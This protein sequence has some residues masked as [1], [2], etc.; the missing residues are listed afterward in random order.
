MHALV[1]ALPQIAATADADGYQDHFNHAW[2]SYTG[3]SEQ[4][5][6]GGKSALHPEDFPL[7]V[8]K[9]SRALR[10]GR[11]DEAE[12]RL[13]RADGVYR[14]HRIQALP[15]RDEKGIVFKWFITI[16][17]V[18]RQKL[19]GKRG[20]GRKSTR[21]SKPYSADAAR[22][23]HRHYVHRG[24]FG[25]PEQPEKWMQRTGLAKKMK[26]NALP[27][28]FRA[29]NFTDPRFRMLADFLPQII[30]TADPGGYQDFFNRQWFDLTGFTERE[31]Y[32]GKTALHPDDF[33]EY[34]ERWSRALR[35]GKA[36]EAEYRFF[37]ASDKTYRWHLVRG[38]PI[39]DDKGRIVKWF[40][41]FT[42]IHDMKTAQKAL[43]ESEQKYRDLVEASNSIILKINKDHNITFINDFGLKFFGYRA[44][45]LIGKN[46]IGTIVPRYD[47]TGRNLAR[48]VRDVVEQPE[49]YKTNVHKNMRKNGELV[50]VSWTN[51]PTYDR[52]GNLVSILAI[53]NDISPLKQ[54]EQALRESELRFKTITSH[55]PDHL[56]VQDRKLRYIF[57]LNPQLGFTEK[58]ML[59]KT[60]LELLRNEDGKRLMT[61]K[62]RAIESGKVHSFEIPITSPKGETEFF[63]GSYVP[64]FDAKGT[65]DGIIGYVRNVT[66]RKRVEDAL[67]LSEQKFSMAFANNPAA[68]V[69]TR[70]SDGKFLDV[71]DTWMEWL[72]YSRK[73]AFATTASKI[74]F[75]PHPKDRKRFVRELQRKGFIR[76]WEQE[77]RKKSGELFT[78]QISAQILNVRGEKV[79]LSTMI[80]IT[81]RKKAEEKIRLL[82]EGL[83]QRVRERTA[84]LEKL[85]A[86]DR[87]NLLRLQDI[88]DNV[89]YGIIALDEEGRVIHVNDQ[90]CQLFHFVGPQAILGKSAT[91]LREKLRKK[92]LSSEDLQ[93]LHA[94][95]KDRVLVF[96]SEIRLK[97]GRIFSRDYIPIFE[98]DV[99]HGHIAVYRDISREKRVDAAK[100]DFMS[101]ASHQLRTPLTAVRWALGRLRKEMDPSSESARLMS[102]AQ[103]AVRGMA[104]TINTMLSISRFEAGTIPL[105]TTEIP[106]VTFLQELS[107]TLQEELAARHQRLMVNCPSSSYIVTDRRLLTEVLLNLIINAINYSPE[108]TCITVNVLQGEEEVYLE[109]KDQGYGIPAHEQNRVFQKFFRGENA[110][111]ALADGSGLGL[112]LVSLLVR[113]LQGTVKFSSQ[114]GKGTTF[115]VT[116]PANIVTDPVSHEKRGA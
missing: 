116:L 77:L 101:L 91:A 88:I 49:S 27:E 75:W 54:V 69:M 57:V 14:W 103:K 70:L 42:D 108:H 47:D 104:E 115:T 2:F 95:D 63:E 98:K 13:R 4:E 50:W 3:L 112:Y 12:F 65:V 82:N 110:V 87:A 20:N 9:W 97:D 18:E 21:P 32:A 58:D 96:G 11:P 15:L 44:Q 68:I 55:T 111:Q 48:M 72:G 102:A 53:G 107:D 25:Y 34:V 29:I 39:H 73:E 10:V 23:F 89:Q 19:D 84:E 1:E 105:N 93:V 109:V 7:Y 5:T 79:I 85:R 40:G 67:R 6:Y 56:F 26:R 31:T 38:L 66:E 94:T 16:S 83:E 99:F 46:V 45:E 100:S 30:W 90:Y 64:K 24:L 71:N 33:R 60:D 52:E 92:L 59:G 106:L 62:K 22:A 8:Q 74:H 37:R 28:L 17:D 41:T 114:E 76:N 86:Q 51:K 113:K 35:E 80:D 61:L 43:A 81:G 36:Y 78:V